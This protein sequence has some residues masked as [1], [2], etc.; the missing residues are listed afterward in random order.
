MALPLAPV[1]VAAVKYGTVA[2]VAYQVARR[3]ERGRT[4]QAGED[5]LDRVPEGVTVHRPGD[6]PNQGNSTVRWRRVVRLD[7]TGPGVEIDVAGM[8]RVKFR[9]V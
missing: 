2:M 5:A 9:R 4:D 7:S 6:R 8:A 3:V 1:A